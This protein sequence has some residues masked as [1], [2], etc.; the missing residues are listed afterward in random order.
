MPVAYE[1]SIV[2]APPHSPAEPTSPPTF[3]IPVTVEVEYELLIA[4]LFNIPAN[5]PTVSPVPV[6]TTVP[7]DQEF[8]IFEYSSK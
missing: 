2:D 1:S 3:E 8:S 4:E 6:P 7:L 5:P